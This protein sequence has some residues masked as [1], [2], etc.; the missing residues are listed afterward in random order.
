M[1]LLIIG[2][3]LWSC[4]HLYPSIFSARRDAIS[5]RMGKSYKGIYAVCIV[6]SIVLIV[7][8]WKHTIPEQV[9]VNPSWGR[10]LNMLTMFFAIM[11]LGAGSSKGISRIKQYIRH[12]MLMGIV[13][14]S[15]GHLLAN[16]DIRSLILFGGMLVWAIVSM[17][18]INRR[19]GAW[20]KPTEIA[21]VKREGILLVITI[22]VYL[23]L[24]MTHRFFAGMPLV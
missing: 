22:V 10:H 4:V 9:Y 21:G 19:D 3:L 20:V 7:I 16:G 24:F 5:E 14:W 11:L 1:N 15:V 17:I 12:P 23:V 6:F 8:G 2:V 18:T 13:V